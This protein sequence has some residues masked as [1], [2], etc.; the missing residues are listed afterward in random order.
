MHSESLSLKQE[1]LNELEESVRIPKE[2]S[3]STDHV[4]DI[5][6]PL[7][8]VWCQHYCDYWSHRG[9]KKKRISMDPSEPF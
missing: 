6:W 8:L 5:G 7:S 4:L 2:P 9:S 3:R 1:W